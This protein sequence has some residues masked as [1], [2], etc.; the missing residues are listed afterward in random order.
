MT[1]SFLE[2]AKTGNRNALIKREIIRQYLTG[3]DCS[4]T[5]LSREMNLSV[6]TVTRLVGELIEEGFVHDFGKQ[7]TNGGRRPNIY[8]LNPDAGYFVGVEVK[9]GNLDF[10]VINFKGRLIE[11]RP[12]IAFELSDSME[13]LDA[14]CARVGAFIDSLSVPREKVLSIGFNLSGRVDS[15]SG[16]S[17][18]YYYTE[19]KPLTQLLEE[20]LGCSVNIENDS[21]AMAYGEY[22]CGGCNNESTVLCIN[23]S[24]GLG[25]G[26]IID[27]RLFYGNS[28]FSGEFGHFPFFDNE[29]ICRCGKRGCLETGA[30][31]IAVHRIFREKLQ[32]GRVSLL[33]EQ[34]AREGNV[35]LDDILEALRSEDVLSIEVVEQVSHNL[36]KAIAGLINLFNPRL[37]VIGGTLSAAGQYLM[38]AVQGAVCKYSLQLVSKDTE[39]RLSTLGGKAGVLGA[40]MLARSKTLSLL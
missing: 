5:D 11:Y 19:D 38:L 34:F 30:S 26:I 10:G 16:Y 35:S 39:I 32:E 3:G 25:V 4:L 7:S 29:I 15:Q 6:P 22:M 23:A 2:D 24:W 13:S 8:G 21:R 28:G 27:G 36:G 1:T 37:I 40:C 9:N 31:G 18:S 14:L 12:D 20:R 17:F 33:S